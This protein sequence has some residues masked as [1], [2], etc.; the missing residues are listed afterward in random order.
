M[1]YL[2]DNAATVYFAVF[3]SFWGKWTDAFCLLKLSNQIL[4]IF[5]L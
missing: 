5:F 1:S 4:S 2:F 3:V